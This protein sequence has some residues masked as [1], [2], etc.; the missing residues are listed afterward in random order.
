MIVYN[1]ELD[2][3]KRILDS[4]AAAEIDAI[5]LWDMAVLSLAKERGLNIHISTQA[6]VSNFEALKFYNSLGAKR[7]VLA[8]ECSLEDITNI[9]ERAKEE[10]IN[11]GIETFVHGAMCLS[12]SGRC[13]LS[14]DTFKKSAN[15]GECIQ[16]CRREFDIVD[17]DGECSYVLG[18]DYILS[19]KDLCAI[20]FIEEFIT[21]GVDAVKIEGRMRPPEY[22][23]VVTASYKTAMD[24]FFEGNLDE[25]LK[26]RLKNDLKKVFN[27]GFTSGFYFNRPDGEVGRN[28]REY[29]KTYIGEVIKFYKKIGVAE[30]SI[31]SG[32]LEKGQ[33]ILV[34]GKK[35]PAN[36]A[37]ITE[38]QMEHN[39]VDIARKG[40]KVGVKVPFEARKK[41]K[42]FL[43]KEQGE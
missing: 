37:N 4:A 12:I 39:S 3:V 43:W 16:P 32:A 20:D 10:K 41:D 35:T 5:V 27:R 18:E 25:D 42:V 29:E 36:F 6:S 2:M 15:R 34:T 24:A 40:D 33:K 28:Q 7:A 21:A 1:N 30:I 38:M 17:K 11:C 31:K 23:K 9:K 13:L 14:Q 19:A 26:K 22:V 8:R